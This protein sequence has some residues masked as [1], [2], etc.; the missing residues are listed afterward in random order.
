MLAAAS[1]STTTSSTS[2]SSAAAAAVTAASLP[3][4]RWWLVQGAPQTNFVAQLHPHSFRH[5]LVLFVIECLSKKVGGGVMGRRERSLLVL[6][7]YVYIPSVFR[8]RRCP[9]SA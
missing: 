2:S 1:T 4:S 7:K 3:T 6:T 8:G 9:L 5:T